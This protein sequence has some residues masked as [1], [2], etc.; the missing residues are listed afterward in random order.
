M[1]TVWKNKFAKNGL[2]FTDFDDRFHC[3]LNVSSDL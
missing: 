3:A 2:I 1:L